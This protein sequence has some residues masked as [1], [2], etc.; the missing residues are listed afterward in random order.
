MEK[1]D[2]L[3]EQA[4]DELGS[5][6]LKKALWAKALAENDGDEAKAQAQ[7]IQQRV[8]ALSKKSSTPK[9]K[10]KISPSSET[11]KNTEAKGRKQKTAK[12]NSL[13]SQ[14]QV[15]PEISITFY[16]DSAPYI[17]MF[18]ALSLVIAGMPSA[19][20]K[21]SL[22]SDIPFILRSVAPFLFFVLVYT[23]RNYMQALQYMSRN[24]KIASILAVG[25]FG[26]VG[27]WNLI[28]DQEWSSVLTFNAAY[29]GSCV[30]LL[31]CM[32]GRMPENSAINDPRAL[33]QSQIRTAEKARMILA[34]PIL[35]SAAL[36]FFFL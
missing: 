17:A 27:N 16:K 13:G 24:S 32:A 22:F 28:E 34:V 21:Y 7:Y 4:F 5:K 19:Q 6:G 11:K 35:G 29:V 23:G 1:E 12:N 2:I 14:S 18:S 26:M 20:G 9:G 10:K 33:K 31:G 3:Y 25:F 30:I 8:S 36:A 15:Q